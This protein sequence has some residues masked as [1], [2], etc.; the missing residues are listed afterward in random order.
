M[1]P[2]YDK[3][4]ITVEHTTLPAVQ[5][6][7]YDMTGREI[8]QR[9]HITETAGTV[10]LQWESSGWAE[11]MYFVTIHTGSGKIPQVI[12]AIKQ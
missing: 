12:K 4:R 8:H 11:G 7:V 6:A 10:E 2:F 3:F 5:V 1:N 9:P